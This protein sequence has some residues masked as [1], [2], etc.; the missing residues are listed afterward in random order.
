MGIWDLGIEHENEHENENG[1]LLFKVR[2]LGVHVRVFKHACP[3]AL[4]FFFCVI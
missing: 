2:S 4:I 3:W 1:L